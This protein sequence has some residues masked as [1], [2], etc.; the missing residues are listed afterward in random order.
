LPSRRRRRRRPRSRKKKRRKKTTTTKKQVTRAGTLDYMAPEVLKCPLKRSPSDGKLNAPSIGYGHGVDV[1]AVGCLAYELCAGVT[2]FR[3]PDGSKERTVQAIQR[4]L[5]GGGAGGCF[6]W[7]V[8]FS[9]ELRS[10]VTAALQPDPARRPSALELAQHPWVAQ[11]RR[12]A[13]QASM[14]VGGGAG[15]A[16]SRPPGGGMAAV[17]AASA[18]AS[19]SPRRAPRATVDEVGR[20]VPHLVVS[21]APRRAA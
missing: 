18:S 21:P 13:S 4:G 14:A 20:G 10:F 15:G 1:W 5:F 9:D 6:V 3:S 7:P 2:P 16:A 8:R 11:Y 19:A 12:P 17:A